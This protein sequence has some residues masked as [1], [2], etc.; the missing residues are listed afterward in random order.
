MA[1]LLQ[2]AVTIN[3]RYNTIADTEGKRQV[4]DATLVLTG[5]GGATNSIAATLLGLQSIDACDSIVDSSNNVYIGVPSYDRTLLILTNTN[6]VT[7]TPA[8]IT[9]TVRAVIRGLPTNFAF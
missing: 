4:V 6:A 2:S 8:D 9:A 1:A 3:T 7:G 5:Q